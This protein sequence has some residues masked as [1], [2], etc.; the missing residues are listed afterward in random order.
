MLASC[1]EVQDITLRGAE[2]KNL[3]GFFVHAIH[4]CQTLI[5]CDNISSIWNSWLRFV[6][7]ILGSGFCHTWEKMMVLN[8]KATMLWKELDD[9]NRKASFTL[10]VSFFSAQDRCRKEVLAIHQYIPSHVSA[11]Y[12]PFPNIWTKTL[13]NKTL[14]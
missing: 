13:K 5:M 10:M 4:K 3:K 1:K 14:R 8:C 9:G 11:H 12:L 6:Y 7:E 2:E